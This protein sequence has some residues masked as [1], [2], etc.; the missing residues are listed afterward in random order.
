MWDVVRAV[1]GGDGV[2]EVR[3]GCYFYAREESGVSRL[4]LVA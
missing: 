3:K 2:S 4:D 1:E